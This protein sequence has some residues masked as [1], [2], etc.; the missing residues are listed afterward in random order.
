MS[1]EYEGKFNDIIIS[2]PENTVQL[3]VEVTV[4][5]NGKTVKA[6]STYDLSDVREAMRLF[7]DCCAGE[8]PLYTLTDKGREMLGSM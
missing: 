2:I 3:D 5:E 7:E 4:F 6:T 8:Y 1:K